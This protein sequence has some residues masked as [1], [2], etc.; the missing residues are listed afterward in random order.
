MKKPCSRLVALTLTLAGFNGAC[1]A[2]DDPP[3]HAVDEVLAA[4][5]RTWTYGHP[6]QYNEFAGMR[7][8]RA[9]HYDCALSR[10]KEAAR[11][12]D[13][14]SQLSIGL[15]YLNG[16]GVEKDPVTAFAWVA[17]AAERKYRQFLA[18]RDR[19]W[20]GLD[21]SQREQAKALVE[22]LY[23]QYGDPVA[24][25]RMARTLRH[26]RSKMSGSLLGFDVGVVSILPN[27]KVPVCGA[28]TIDGAPIVGCG[29]LFVGWRWEPDA[30]FASRDAAWTGTVTVGP[31]R[32]VRPDAASAHP[33]TGGNPP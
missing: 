14:L 23:A 29:N 21:A 17:I 12:A 10:F 11:Y 13:K 1:M 9:R 18:T 5:D 25:P 32:Q 22:R 19:I 31:L 27:G 7:C 33:E 6:D 30:Y 28:P 15:M 4:M 24:K 8:Y 26:Y 2:S 3:E 16:Q 20:A